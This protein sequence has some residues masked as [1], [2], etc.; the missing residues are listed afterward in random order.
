MPT[1]YVDNEAV[2]PKFNISY[3]RIRKAVD[4]A[5]YWTAQEF[6]KIIKFIVDVIRQDDSFVELSTGELL[7]TPLEEYLINDT[8]PFENFDILNEDD[9]D[10]VSWMVYCVADELGVV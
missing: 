4:Y 5:D 10:F 7:L 1:Y 9:H 2:T 6:D 3:H 8:I